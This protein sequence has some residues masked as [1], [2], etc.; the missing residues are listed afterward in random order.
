ME[1]GCRSPR[2]DDSKLRITFYHARPV[3][4]LDEWNMKSIAFVS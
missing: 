1:F 2:N 4:R 3:V